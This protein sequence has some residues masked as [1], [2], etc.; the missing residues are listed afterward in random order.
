MTLAN[1]LTLTVAGATGSPFTLNRVNQDNFGSQ[2]NFIDAAQQIVM[3]IRQSTEVI[4]GVTVF[5]HNAVVEHTIFATPLAH[6]KFATATIT[7]RDSKGY[8]PSALLATWVG[9]NNL[10]LTLDDQV[11]LGD[12]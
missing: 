9:F 12:N 1:T 4:K 5:R 2:Y 7:L 8:S 6:E 11:V 10:F 3:K